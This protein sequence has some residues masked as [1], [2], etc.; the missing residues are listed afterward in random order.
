MHCLCSRLAWTEG[1]ARGTCAG[2]L[3]G[4]RLTLP[5]QQAAWLAGAMGGC[6]WISCWGSQGSAGV[7]QEAGAGGKQ[8]AEHSLQPITCIGHWRLHGMGRQQGAA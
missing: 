8:A 4:Q 5:M 6:G 3:G 1:G 2:W 7:E